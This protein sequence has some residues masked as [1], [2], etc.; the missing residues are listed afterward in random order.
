MLAVAGLGLALSQFPLARSSLG[1]VGLYAPALL[2]AVSQ[3][4]A[5]SAMSAILMS[6]VVVVALL[7]KPSGRVLRRPRRSRR[8]RRSMAAMPS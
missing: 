5:V 8:I 1:H 2:M 6:G 3:V 4:H 7:T